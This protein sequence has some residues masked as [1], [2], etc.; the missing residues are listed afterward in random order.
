MTVYSVSTTLYQTIES[1]N[2][3]LDAPPPST[4]PRRPWTL[5]SPPDVTQPTSSYGASDFQDII[6]NTAGHTPAV[7]NTNFIEAVAHSMGFQA[8]D[9]D[10]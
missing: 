1:T 3:S 5:T 6:T 4:Q 2:T 8:A 7:V 9:E 10:Y